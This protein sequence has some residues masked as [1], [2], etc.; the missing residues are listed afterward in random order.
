[1]GAE[2]DTLRVKGQV[3]NLPTCVQQRLGAIGKIG[4][5]TDERWQ[6]IKPTIYTKRKLKTRGEESGKKFKPKESWGDFNGG[7]RPGGPMKW[8][9]MK[10]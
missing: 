5:D 8:H 1:M 10:A 6:T 2:E 3:Q 9:K 7:E 4:K